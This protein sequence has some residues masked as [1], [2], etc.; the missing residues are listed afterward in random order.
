MPEAVVR[1]MLGV[2]CTQLMDSSSS[3]RDGK[4]RSRRRGGEHEVL[5]AAAGV[6]DVELHSADRDVRPEGDASEQD[7][8]ALE[9]RHAVGEVLQ[10]HLRPVD[11]G[12]EEAALAHSVPTGWKSRVICSVPSDAVAD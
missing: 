4:A 8:S 10:Q 9:V 7:A 5:V 12:R 11:G 2:S 3:E 1:A 6:D